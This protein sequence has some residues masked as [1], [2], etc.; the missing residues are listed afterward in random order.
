MRIE[1]AFGL[2]TVHTYMVVAIFEKRHTDF[3]PD[4][5]IA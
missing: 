4:I 2:I 3:T 1:P 5:I